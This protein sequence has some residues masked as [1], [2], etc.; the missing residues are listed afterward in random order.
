MG[1]ILS[2]SDTNE[3]R[4]KIQNLNVSNTPINYDILNK[5]NIRGEKITTTYQHY[6]PDINVEINNNDIK[7]DLENFELVDSEKGF[8]SKINIYQYNNFK[9]VEKCYQYIKKDSKWYVTDDFVK[10]SFENELSSLMILNN[11][12]NFPK[13]LHYDKE[14][15]RLIMT[16]NGK[17]LA[18]KQDHID[19][20]TIPSNWK[21][22]MY[23]IL[24][25]L[26]K[27]NLYHNDITVRNMCLHNDTLYLIDFGNCKNTID[28]YYRNFY[29]DMLLNSESI[30][31]FFNKIDK[32]AYEIRKC[33]Y[34]NF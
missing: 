27:Y 6:A 5:P 7:N 23:H 4:L 28:F 2:T 9:V 24:S 20:N 12:P 13:I 16:Y 15:M 34:G 31:D 11:E 29:S 10:E 21:F 26:K 1:N 22:Q 30:I 19:L 17:K 8:T 32:N 18:D 33:R 3:T 14:N 25:V